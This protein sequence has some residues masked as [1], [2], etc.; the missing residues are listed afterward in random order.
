MARKYDQTQSWLEAPPTW[1]SN[2]MDRIN[3]YC[4]DT[5]GRAIRMGWKNKPTV[6][7]GMPVVHVHSSG[8]A[9]RHAFRINAGKDRLDAE[10]VILH[11]VAHV[12]AGWNG[13]AKGRQSSGEIGGSHDGHCTGFYRTLF[14]EVVPRF[15]SK[16]LTWR[17]VLLREYEYKPRNAYK[18]A[19]ELQ[20]PGYK[21]AWRDRK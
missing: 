5:Y 7:Y 11:E 19:K 17:Y 3:N 10:E 15:K 21:K 12:I 1:A 16:K 8:K 4:R 9:Y 13:K 20:L 18:V 6:S 2:L 14:D